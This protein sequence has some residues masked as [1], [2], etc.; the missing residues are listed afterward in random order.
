MQEQI[1]PS[2]VDVLL[3]D[4]KRNLAK[5]E[6]QAG[7]DFTNQLQKSKLL[8]RTKEGT[9]DRVMAGEIINDAEKCT[10]MD[11]W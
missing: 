10:D 2:K 4:V 8:E 11:G 6:T 3:K 1:D 7:A 9:E 5:I